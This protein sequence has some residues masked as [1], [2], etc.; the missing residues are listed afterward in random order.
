VCSSVSSS[1]GGSPKKGKRE[2]R[3]GPGKERERE[4]EREVVGETARECVFFFGA[5]VYK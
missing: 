2:R 1:R 4:K 5:V 3:K